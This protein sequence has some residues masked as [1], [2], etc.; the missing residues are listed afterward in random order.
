MG[1]IGFSIIS[2]S[3]AMTEVKYP[4][5]I[6]LPWKNILLKAKNYFFLFIMSAVITKLCLSEAETRHL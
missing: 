5:P 3:A 2:I 1:K 6:N 4:L